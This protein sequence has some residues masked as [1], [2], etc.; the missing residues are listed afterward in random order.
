MKVIEARDRTGGRIHT[1]QMGEAKVD[2][3]GQWI[4]GIGKSVGFDEKGRWKGQWNPVYQIA[5]DNGIE[6]VRSYLEDYK[7]EKV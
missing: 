5:L 6:L 3:G 4:H 7:H 2:L 1:V